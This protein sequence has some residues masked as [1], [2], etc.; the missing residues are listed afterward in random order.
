MYEYELTVP[1][2]TSAADPLLQRFALSAGIL[3]HISV[4]FPP[5]PSA[6]AHVQILYQN[7]QIEPWN[8][9]W[10]YSLG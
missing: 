4:Y 10:E 3:N 2:N 5:G 9:G 8:W 1:A 7:Y 6:L